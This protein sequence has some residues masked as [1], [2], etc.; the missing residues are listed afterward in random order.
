M[1]KDPTTTNAKLVNDTIQRFKKEKLL[2]KK[3]PDGLK[4][5]NQKTPKF[6]MQPKIH[7]KITWSTSISS[8][9]CRTSSVSKY[10]DYHLQPIVKEIPSYV[11]DTKD[12]LSMLIHIRDIAKEIL[13]AT[14]DV[15]SLYT[16]IPK[17]GGIK[18]IRE[19]YNKHP[20]KSVS[21]K[22]IITF[23]SLIFTLNNF[24]FN[25]S[26]YPQVMGCAMGTIIFAIKILAYLIFLW[27]N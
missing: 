25:Y 5:P 6:Y 13:L 7:K 20:S 8:A 15:K 17:N 27:H 26:H 2:K 14:L 18:A 24:I 23:L 1:N 10:V 11:R 19:A 12:F 16:I 4:V 3:I 22:V 21:T 9:N